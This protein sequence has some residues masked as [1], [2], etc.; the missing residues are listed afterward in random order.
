MSEANETLIASAVVLPE[1]SALPMIRHNTA[2]AYAKRLIDLCLSL[3]AIVLLAPLFVVIA[4]A[5]AND[6]GPVFYR[7][8]RLGRHATWFRCI[9]FR[10]MVQN[11]DEILRELLVQDPQALLEWRAAFKLKRDPRITRCGSFLRKTSLD[12]L[13]QLFN[14]FFGQMS[15]V[16]PRPIV[17]AEVVR[18]GRDIMHYYRCRPGITGPWQ[19]SGRNDTSY[20]TRVRM[21]VTYAQRVSVWTDISIMLRTMKVVV[22]CTGAY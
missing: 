12:E 16:G 4:I 3:T 22:G 14:V 19:V 11:A 17:A 10:T 9:K 18:Y 5:V 2:T 6:G 8:Y 13:P 1:M 21:D 20:S 15:L 7:Q